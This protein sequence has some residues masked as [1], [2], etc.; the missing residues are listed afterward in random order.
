MSA[1]YSPR[2][3]VA[4]RELALGLARALVEVSS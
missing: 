4:G 3:L 2:G 1:A